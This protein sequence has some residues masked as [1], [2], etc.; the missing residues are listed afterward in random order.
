MNMPFWHAGMMQRIRFRDIAK[1]SDFDY[2]HFENNILHASMDSAQNVKNY[3]K[4]CRTLKP[5]LPFVDR[6]G[7]C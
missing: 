6:I 4:S 7:S 2:Y 3:I 1:E 5:K